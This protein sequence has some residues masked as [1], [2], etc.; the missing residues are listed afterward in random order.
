MQI[1]KI[2][3]MKNNKYKLFIDSEE[4]VTYDNVILENDL[5]YKK[6]MDN[7]LYNKILED[8]KYYDIYNKTVKY[9]LKRRRSEKEVRVYLNKF[10]I[11]NNKINNMIIKLKGIKLIDDIEYSKAY[12]NDK[13]YL[14][15]IGINKIKKDLLEQ[16]ISEDIISNC[17]KEIDTS[18][19]KDNLEKI[20]LKKIKS[21]SKYSN[22]YLK[23]KILVDMTRKGYSKS[24]I[25]NIIDSSLT[26]DD[27]ILNKEFE[28]NYNILSKKYVGKELY[29]KLKQ[30]LI[31]KGFEVEKINILLQEKTE[32]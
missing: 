23:Q 21:N 13:I 18:E 24:D 9:I 8:T 27:N 1:N 11:N 32:D 31:S 5:L 7:K 12:I 26:S 20:I 14:D 17:L 16:N 28:K 3:K 22:N 4:I 29:I 2:V 6:S 19:I 25:I 10:N 30:K 15:K